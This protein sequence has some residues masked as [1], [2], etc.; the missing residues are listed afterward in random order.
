VLHVVHGDLIIA[1]NYK[2]ASLSL[3]SF[4]SYCFAITCN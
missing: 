3:F 4:V 1:D 2:F